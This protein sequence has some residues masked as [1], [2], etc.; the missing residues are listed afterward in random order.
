MVQVKPGGYGILWNSEL[1][2]SEGEL[3]KRGRIRPLKSYQR[4]KLFLRSDLSRL[5]AANK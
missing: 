4:T 1:D 2:C 5:S 3:W